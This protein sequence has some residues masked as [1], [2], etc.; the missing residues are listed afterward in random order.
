VS[1]TTDLPEYFVDLAEC[2]NGVLAWKSNGLWLVEA[3]GRVELAVE[4]ARPIRGVWDHG[5][6][7]CV[8]VGD[9][10]S[11][12]TAPAVRSSAIHTAGPM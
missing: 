9:L 7:F 10:A 11:F 6:G 12:Q 5:A 3:S 2:G 4:T 8:L 1:A